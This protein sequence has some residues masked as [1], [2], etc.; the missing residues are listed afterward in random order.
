M[1]QAPR[2]TRKFALGDYGPDIEGVARALC[3]AH[4]G[5]PLAV[6]NTLPLRVR[7]TWGR[8]KQAWLV[9]FKRRHELPGSPLYGERTHRALAPHFDSRA[10]WLM[11]KWE[12]LPERCHPIPA[13]VRYSI[14]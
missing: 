8:Q 6:F 11:R 3:H 1:A 5:P 13:A 9:K 14:V 12:P 10:R 4:A 7:R 2:Y